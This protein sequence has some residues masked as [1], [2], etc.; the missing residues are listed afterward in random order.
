MWLRVSRDRIPWEKR[1]VLPQIYRFLPPL[2]ALSLQ[3]QNQDETPGEGRCFSLSPLSRRNSDQRWVVILNF[4][5]PTNRNSG[6]K[7]R[8]ANFILFPGCFSL[9][10]LTSPATTQGWYPGCSEIYFVPMEGSPSPLP[11][12]PKRPHTSCFYLWCSNLRADLSPFL[13]SHPAYL[14]LCCPPL[15]WGGILPLLHRVMA[16]PS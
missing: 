6:E 10:T 2:P 15:P 12:P 16:F 4:T 13:F 7:I 5:L 8:L 1:P 9:V 14:C 11:Y 3:N